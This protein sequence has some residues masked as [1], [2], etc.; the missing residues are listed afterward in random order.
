MKCIAEAYDLIL[1]SSTRFHRD[2]LNKRHIRR[3][4]G[5]GR[6]VKIFKG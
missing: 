2:R 1:Y 5:L 6:R 4:G 3:I